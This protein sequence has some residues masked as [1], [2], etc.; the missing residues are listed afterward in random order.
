M[1]YMQL[2]EGDSQADGPH[3]GKEDDKLGPC[4]ELI[5]YPLRGN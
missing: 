3:L 2:Y 1:K 4:H 5:L